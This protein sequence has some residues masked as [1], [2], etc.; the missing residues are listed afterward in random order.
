[1]FKKSI[2]LHLIARHRTVLSNNFLL[3]ARGVS[4]FSEQPKGSNFSNFMGLNK[5][6]DRLR[7]EETKQ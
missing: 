5:E 7:K 2:P 1:M 3:F 4:L 6:L